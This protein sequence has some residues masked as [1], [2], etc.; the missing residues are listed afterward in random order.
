MP[1]PNVFLEIQHIHNCFSCAN[2]KGR[3]ILTYE[4]QVQNKGQRKPSVP[5]GVATDVGIRSFHSIFA[6]SLQLANPFLKRLACQETVSRQ[7]SNMHVYSNSSSH[8]HLKHLIPSL[9]IY[10]FPPSLPFFF[11]KKDFFHFRHVFSQEIR[12]P[13][14]FQQT[15]YAAPKKPQGWG[16]VIKEAEALEG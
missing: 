12:G 15:P 2:K 11:L 8:H 14:S 13:G 16:W 6:E 4:K 10:R 1:E 9:F 5:S 7:Y 3:K